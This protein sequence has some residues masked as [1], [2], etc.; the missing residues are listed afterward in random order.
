MA[1]HALDPLSSTPRLHV[2]VGAGEGADGIAG[3]LAHEAGDT[4]LR[5][6]GA[7]RLQLAGGAIGRSTSVDTHL[8]GPVSAAIAKH[9]VRRTAVGVRLS[10]VAEGIA[11]EEGVALA[12]RSMHRDVRRDVSVDQ[13]AEQPTGPYALSAERLTGS[14]PSLVSMR[15][16]SV[17]VAATSAAKRAGVAPPR[18]GYSRC[19]GRAGG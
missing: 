1:E 10:V 11:G 2:A 16:T 7:L 3:F 5:A 19:R 6:D 17:R 9:L 8:P 14:M 18:R 4:P 13:P 15:D 12:G